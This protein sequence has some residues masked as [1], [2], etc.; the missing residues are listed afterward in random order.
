LEADI[1]YID[2]DGRAG[3]RTLTQHIID[4]GHRVIGYVSAPL[5]LMFAQYRLQGYQDALQFNGLHYDESLLEIGTLTEQDGYEAARRLLCGGGAT[6]S[7][8][9]PSAIIASN[10]LMALGIINAVRECG[11]RVGKDVAV[12]GFDDIPV[13]KHA[14]PPLTTVR[15][16]V[17]EIG[18]R[19]CAMLIQ[20][21]TGETLDE[22]Q[23]LLQPELVIRQSTMTI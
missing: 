6:L 3:L 2:V 13:S 19:S 9:R 1:P 15:Q 17:Y 5:D 11:L 14:Q 20:L 16:P 21:M 7:P 23:V 8:E 18:R 10:D 22:S 4:L 12:A